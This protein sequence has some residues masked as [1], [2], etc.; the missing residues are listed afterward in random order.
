MLSGAA[1]RIYSGR[2]PIVHGPVAAQRA[3][4]E[5]GVPRGRT[6]VLTRAFDKMQFETAAPDVAPD[7]EPELTSVS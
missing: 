7:V 3:S 4:G 2:H 1:G 6:S 5:E